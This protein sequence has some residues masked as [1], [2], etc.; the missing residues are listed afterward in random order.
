[1]FLKEDCFRLGNIARLHGFKGELSV[2]L[3][4][5]DPQEYKELESVFIEVDGKLVPFFIDQIRMSNKGFAV[6]RFDGVNS[7]KK[8]KMLLKCGL[9][10]PLDL[11]PEREDDEFYYFEI[12]G[13]EVIDA[14]HGS[15]GTVT[16]VID[17]SGNPLIQ[18]DHNGQEILLP[19]QD[20]FILK[21]DHENQQ[22][23]IQAPE[24][25]IEMY[26]G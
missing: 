20:E 16:K 14:K 17:L 1:M 26:L 21:A 22:L 12:E 3:D 23:H 9:Y 13:Y 18:I 25:L 6:I 10:L 2:F 4:V 5:D 8:A 15:I 11:L 19:K 24:G 7:E